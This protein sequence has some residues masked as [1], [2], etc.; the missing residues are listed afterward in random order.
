[1]NTTT[2]NGE[3]KRHGP[4]LNPLVFHALVIL[5]VSL[6]WF[7]SR[8]F[9]LASFGFFGPLVLSEL[10][11]MK[12]D[13]FKQESKLRAGNR[14]FLFGGVFLTLIISFNGCHQRYGQN[15]QEIADVIPASLILTVMLAVYYLSDLVRYWGPRKAAFRILVVYSG[16]VGCF[17]ALSLVLRGVGPKGW[18]VNELIQAGVF[19]AITV[20]AAIISTKHTWFA[21]CLMLPT[22]AWLAVNGGIF[23]AITTSTAPWQI[24]FDV[25]IYTLL[26]PISGIITLLVSTRETEEQ[27]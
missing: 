7:D 11:M 22:T 13:E 24:K 12:F 25:V 4:R 10:G 15:F 20:G 9:L 21:I 18:Q 1:M 26:L 5:G 17:I 3:V 16:F 27:D 23:S 19:F 2:R 6:M 8:F 14:A